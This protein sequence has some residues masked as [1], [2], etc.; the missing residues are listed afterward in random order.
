TRDAWA[1]LAEQCDACVAPV[2]DFIE[3]SQYAHNLDNRLYEEGSASDDHGAP[4]PGQ[5]GDLTAFVRP[6]QVLSFS[7]L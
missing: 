4:Q 5:Q 1:T 6:G 7:A 2:L 3:A